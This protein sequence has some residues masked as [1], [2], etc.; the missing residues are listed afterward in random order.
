MT[1]SEC[2]E[3]LSQISAYLDGDL[4][5]GACG[6]I[7]RHCTTCTECAAIVEDLRKTT[8]LCRQLGAAPLPPAV[9]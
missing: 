4:D 9:L 3:M 5:A 8:G 7:E 2:K 6:V 1:K